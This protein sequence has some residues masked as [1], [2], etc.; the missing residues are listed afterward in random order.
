MFL[1]KDFN[2]YKR[3][4]NVS[5]FIMLVEF[6][7]SRNCTAEELQLIEFLAQKGNYFLENNW[8]SKIMAYPLTD[9]L[10]GSIGLIDT[11][12]DI[13][14]SKENHLIAD[15]QFLDTDGVPV[16]VYLL[17]D[18]EG[19]LDELDIWK[20]DYSTINRIPPM[21]NMTDVNTL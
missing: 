21:S 18:S 14:E 19:K 6:M 12:I 5:A 17:V 8:K 10:I 4:E 13:Y 3:V 2:I 15:C 16:V 20:C 9:E 1:E 7:E 11:N